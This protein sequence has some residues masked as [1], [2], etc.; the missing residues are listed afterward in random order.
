MPNKGA[1]ERDSR[2]GRGGRQIDSFTFYMVKSAKFT[3]DDLFLL[4]RWGAHK[5]CYAWGGKILGSTLVVKSN[6]YI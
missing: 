5:N 1:G 6:N 3:L 4:H 2:P